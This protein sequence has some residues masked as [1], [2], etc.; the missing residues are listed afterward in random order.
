MQCASA[1]QRIG[2]REM[3][4]FRTILAAGAVLNGLA[5]SS[6]AQVDNALVSAGGAVLADGT[7]LTLG[8]LA[9]GV[10]GTGSSDVQQGAV[11]CW[12]TAP[13]F[14]DLDGNGQIGLT[15]L[16]TLLSHFGTASGAT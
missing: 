2:D 3:M 9:I 1:L 12:S 6:P 5:L 7:L 11:P 14:G 16:T 8:D 15:D 4:R 10:I 13:C